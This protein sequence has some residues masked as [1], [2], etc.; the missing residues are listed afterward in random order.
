[1]FDTIQYKA[2][3]VSKPNVKNPNIMGIIHSIILF[4]DSCCGVVAGVVVI[5]CITHM[6][7]PTNTAMKYVARDLS[8]RARSRPMNW[9]SKGTTW[10]T[11]DSHGYR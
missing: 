8:A 10:C 7:P 6:D 3:P 4:V 9:L 11:T 2:S 1:M 5:F